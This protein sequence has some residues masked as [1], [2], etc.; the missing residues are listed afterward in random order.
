MEE[1]RPAVSVIGA[2]GWGTTLANLLAMKGIPVKIWAY[3]EE[4][5]RNINYKNENPQFLPNI[6][7][8]PRIFAYTELEKVIPKADILIF[9]IP[10]TFVR[11]MAE[12]IS[13]LF[14][15]SR[16]YRLISVSKGLEYE[17]FKLMSEI[18]REILPKNVKIA[19]LSGPNLSR[20][21]AL[22]QPTATVIAS[23]H[24]EILPDLV[25]GVSMVPKSVNF[26]TTSSNNS[27]ALS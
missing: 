8:S 14:I 15:P 1:N 9:A 6:Q 26:S 4:T 17:T 7:L 2:G 22:G 11:M 27:L 24:E 25:M 3:E 16:E 12:K 18:L 10:S 5:V 13:P 23:I 20:E 19:A 21:V